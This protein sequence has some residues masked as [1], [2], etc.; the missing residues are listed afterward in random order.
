MRRLAVVL[1]ALFGCTP[2]G[3]GPDDG[4][5]PLS[6]TQPE[7]T[8]TPEPTAPPPEP[9]PEPTASKIEVHMT[10]ATLADDCGGGPNRP[11]SAEPKKKAAKGRVAV[12]ELA[13]RKGK[14]ACEQSSIQLAI[15]APPDAT[16]TKLT[17]K[18]VELLLESGTLV[19]KLEVRAPSIW[20]DD[21]GYTPWDENV[22]PAQ[23]LSVTYAMTQPDW[24]GVADRWNQTFTVKAVVSIAG[25]DTTLEHAVVVDAPTSLPPGVK[26]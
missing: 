26:T 16:P 11:P 18:S 24:S 12:S 4:K 22:E 10:S 3:P 15:I 6:P 1:V 14:R 19:G 20:S 5:P 23:D 2:T 21:N 13:M 17:V 9:E 25:T 8:P 7:A